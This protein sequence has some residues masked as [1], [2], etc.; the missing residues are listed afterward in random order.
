MLEIFPEMRDKPLHRVCMCVCM[1]TYTQDLCAT[2]PK[3]IIMSNCFKV[4]PGFLG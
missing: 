4:Q 2:D 3:E 1:L